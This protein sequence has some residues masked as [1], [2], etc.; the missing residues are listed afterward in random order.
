ML[1]T[2]VKAAGTNPCSRLAA[3]NS[4]H[5]SPVLLPHLLIIFAKP[6]ID[7]SI[8]LPE[9]NTEKILGEVDMAEFSSNLTADLGEADKLPALTLPIGSAWSQ[10]IP[11]QQ[12][13]ATGSTLENW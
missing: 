9:T 10:R 3:V 7:T 4:K 11:V 1:L 2:E 6:I 12:S 13:R 5:V 8:V